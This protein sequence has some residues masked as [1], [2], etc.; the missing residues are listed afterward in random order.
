M[1]RL[2]R[3][4]LLV[5]CVRRAAV[6]VLMLSGPLLN[7]LGA[8]EYSLYGDLELSTTVTRESLVTGTAAYFNHRLSYEWGE[9]T[10]R[11]RLSLYHGTDDLYHTLYHAAVVIWPADAL[12]VQIGRHSIPWGT[13]SV[14]FPADALHPER[15]RLDD[16]RGFD[17]MSGT[18]TI[19]PEWTASAAVRLDTAFEAEE[20][21]LQNL[22][23]A[24]VVSG[25]VGTVDTVASVVYQH[26]TVLR[27]AAGLSVPLG[28]VILHGEVAHELIG[29]SAAGEGDPD[30]NDVPNVEDPAVSEVLSLYGIPR[31]SGWAVAGGMHYTLF[32]GAH[33]ITP[34]I[35]YL[36]TR[37]LATQFGRRYLY[38]YISWDAD[39]R[40][41]VD[42]SSLVD[43][44]KERAVVRVEFTRNFP[45]SLA[46]GVETSWPV[47]EY[48]AWD[49]GIVRLVAR[50]H[51]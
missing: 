29:T 5:P 16:K 50:A 41:T 23:G 48:A 45:E 7:V 14:F 32:T 43:V 4:E 19:S 12:T 36:Y 28:E 6:L 39:G 30:F 10:V 15:A 33:A 3:N 25:Y 31:D 35:E 26:E 20:R 40:W 13:G 49:D 9:A 18:W 34:A 42:L 47:A 17:G 11:H 44:E 2:W 38:P 37:Q 51:F 8:E 1:K 22:R 24:S 21:P 46:L 27:P